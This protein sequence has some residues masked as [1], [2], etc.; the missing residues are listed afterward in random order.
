VDGLFARADGIA[1]IT[2]IDSSAL[3]AIYKGEGN[4]EDWLN[5]LLKH[6]QAGRLIVCDVVVAEIA[7]LIRI[8]SETFSFL[9]D[10]GVEYDPIQPKSAVL[11]GHI[12]AAYRRGGGPRKHLIPDFLIGAHASRQADQLAVAD[13]GYLRR[14]FPKLKLSFPA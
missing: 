9:D 7:A 10:L 8:D 2:A 4:G 1:V 14:Y 6:R 13:R 3:V 12:F 11:T 5:L